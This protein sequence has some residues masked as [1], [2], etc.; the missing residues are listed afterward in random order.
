MSAQPR[1][2]MR[3]FGHYARW[4]CFWLGLAAFLTYTPGDA[5]AMAKLLQLAFGLTQ[6]LICALIFTALQNRF[7]GQR[8]KPKSWL[9]AIGTL[10]AVNF[11][12]FA[13][14]K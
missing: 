10:L 5:F 4:W 6:G 9:L 11:A 12:A 8:Q 1:Q 7:N 13:I 3:D 2:L 14:F